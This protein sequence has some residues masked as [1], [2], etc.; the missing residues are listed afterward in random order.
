VVYQVFFV[1]HIICLSRQSSA[2]ADRQINPA[3]SILLKNKAER[4]RG[5]H[6]TPER[7]RGSPDDFFCPKPICNIFLGRLNHAFNFIVKV[8]GWTMNELNQTMIETGGQI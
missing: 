6:S 7:I 3:F 5:F 2:S 1:I 4:V 8:W